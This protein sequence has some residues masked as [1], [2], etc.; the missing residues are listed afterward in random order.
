MAAYVKGE[1]SPPLF[2][3]AL[4]PAE[5]LGLDDPGVLRPLGAKVIARAVRRGRP[6]QLRQ[7]LGQAAPA[8]LALAQRFLGD[9]ALVAHGASGLVALL[10]PQVQASAPVLV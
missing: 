8:L 3:S 2:C 4:A 10:M 6:H 5:Q 9:A 1:G 7:R